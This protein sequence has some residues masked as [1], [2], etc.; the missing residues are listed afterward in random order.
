MFSEHILMPEP[1]LNPKLPGI[2]CRIINLRPATVKSR[3]VIVE[4]VVDV[5]RQTHNYST[6][7]I[8]RTIQLF[9][10]LMVTGFILFMLFIHE[11]HTAYP[12]ACLHPDLRGQAIFTQLGR[13]KLCIP[14]RLQIRECAK[15]AIFR[16]YGGVSVRD[17]F[18]AF[19][20]TYKRL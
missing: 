13:G 17:A 10:M 2:H 3:H 1:T 5:K 11:L 18:I 20:G 9:S 4:M 12:K 7:Q 14:R 16:L 15:N 19:E 8:R 6:T